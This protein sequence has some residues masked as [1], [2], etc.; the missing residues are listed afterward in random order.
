MKSEHFDPASNVV[1]Q[2]VLQQVNKLAEA[3]DMPP[4]VA[5]QLV[6]AFPKWS[7]FAF[8]LPFD[9]AGAPD[10]FIP[11]WYWPM[12]MEAIDV[13]FSGKFFLKRIRD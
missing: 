12:M 10:H 13:M 11:L 4:E 9:K 5:E 1:Q 7:F 8:F 6:N 3:L 2:G